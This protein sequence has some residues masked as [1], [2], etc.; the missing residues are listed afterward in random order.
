MEDASSSK[1]FSNTFLNKKKY[2]LCERQEL[3]RL[4][5][6]KKKSG[7]KGFLAKAV[8]EYYID[9][10]TLKNSDTAFRNALKVAKRAYELVNDHDDENIPSSS[11]AN[12]RFRFLLV[13]TY[14][15]VH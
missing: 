7:E 15:S 1:Q 5:T 3:C 10:K 6:E 12:K 9:L 11:K 8:R 14:I 4:C 13:S 2:S